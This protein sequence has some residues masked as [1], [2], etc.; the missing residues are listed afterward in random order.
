MLTLNCNHEGYLINFDSWNR[1]FA[2]EMSKEH[3]LDLTDCHWTVIIFLRDYYTE[4]GIAAEPRE[5]I[6]KIGNKIDSHKPCNRKY[7]EGLFAPDG[8][9]LAC[10]IA[11]LPNNYCRGT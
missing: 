5:I 7:L 8:C 3:N 6:Q 9:K 11:G 2:I 4:Y 10:K 1:D